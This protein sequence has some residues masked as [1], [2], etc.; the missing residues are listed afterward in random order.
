MSARSWLDLRRGRAESVASSRL[1]FDGIR[2]FASFNITGL[3]AGWL[4][5]NSTS[6]TVLLRL[7]E[8]TGEL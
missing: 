8:Q 4:R 7:S 2:T 6:F 1:S 3:F 5:S